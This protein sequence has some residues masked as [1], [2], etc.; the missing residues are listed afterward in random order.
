MQPRKQQ[1]TLFK[2]KIAN[3]GISHLIHLYFIVEKS[4]LKLFQKIKLD[5]LDF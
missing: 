2:L 4:S 3:Q 1:I 5:E